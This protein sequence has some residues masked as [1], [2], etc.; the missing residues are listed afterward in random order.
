MRI[1]YTSHFYPPETAAAATRVSELSRHWARAGHDVH[2]LTGFPH[3]PNGVVPASY[4]NRLRGLTMHEQIDGVEVIRAP[5]IPTS[6][7]RSWKRMVNYSSFMVGAA[8]RGMVMARPDVVI[9]T[10]P[11]L[12]TGIVSWWLALRFKSRFVFEV[13][14]LWPE[15][16]IG[17]GIGGSG[18]QLIAL[19]D[20][21]ANFLYKR[22]DM[23]V[24]VTQAQ[25]D[26]LIAKR[27]VPKERISVVENGVD[28]DLFQPMDKQWCRKELNWDPD[29]FVLSYL[30]NI[31]L[32]QGVDSIL[33]LASSLKKPLPQ[34]RV[35]L[36]GDGASRKN[37]ATQ[38]EE[39]GLDNV[40]MVPLQ[41]RQRVPLYVN[42]SDICLVT[43]RKSEVFETALPSKLLEFMACAR[44]ILLAAGGQARQVLETAQAGLTVD[45]GDIPGMVNAV[46]QLAGEAELRT[47]L[48]QNGQDYVQRHFRRETKA[49]HYLSVL[50]GLI[51]EAT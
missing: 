25:K 16:L 28:D 21:V 31:G 12:L 51:G 36:I 39:S 1:L 32:A 34:A 27:G 29:R 49:A 45:A 38:L 23:I 44:P 9:G 26:N 46:M 3:Y 42:A 48:G 19:L 7:D 18:S 41:P 17:A 24:T 43:L 22:A 13:R 50:E 40:E 2:V 30:G 11:H 10:S 15:S 8:L 35:V 5:V 4:R 37:L 6:N 14:D 33:E 20:R 47:L